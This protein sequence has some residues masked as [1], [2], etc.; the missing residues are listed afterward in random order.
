M[1]ALLI[2]L[3]TPFVMIDGLYA[4]PHAANAEP[5]EA[6]V[7]VEFY[8]NESEYQLTESEA[9]IILYLARWE[10]DR[11]DEGLSVMWCESRGIPTRVNPTSN[12]SG[13][14]QFIWDLEAKYPTC[15]AYVDG[16]HRDFCGWY[17]Y[18]LNE[19]H[20]NLDVFNPLDNAVAMRL[21]GE[22]SVEANGDYWH[23]DRGQCEPH[24]QDY[25]YEPLAEVSP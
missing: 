5:A 3:I 11:I 19:H 18:I 12:A 13:L 15:D 2:S 10:D 9:T 25:G 1:I 17:H 21:V 20:L 4:N 8:T 14:F 24:W 23:Q 7:S 6:W 16:E 22:Y